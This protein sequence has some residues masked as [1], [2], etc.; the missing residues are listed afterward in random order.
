MNTRRTYRTEKP[1]LCAGNPGVQAGEEARCAC[2]AHLPLDSQ[3]QC[4]YA[5][6]MKLTLQLQ[7]LPTVEQKTAL[8][9]M[10]KRFNAAA[11]YAAQ[12]GFVA[13]VFGQVSIHH[14]AY[15]EIRTRFGL[16]SQMAV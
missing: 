7:L 14:L 12:V 10:M 16:S 11:I 1:D 13:G 8:L 5:L 3:Q 4:G 15:T 6:S 9:E 2:G